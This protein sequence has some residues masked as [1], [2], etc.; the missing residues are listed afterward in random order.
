MQN[1]SPAV[2]L[3]LKAFA[4]QDFSEESNFF[5]CREE[6]SNISYI[7][8]KQSKDLPENDRIAFDNMAD[9][10]SHYPTNI[11]Y[12]SHRKGSAGLFNSKKFLNNQEI[13]DAKKAIKQTKGFVWAGIV[14]FTP[15]MAS[16]ICNNKNKA[17]ELVSAHIHKLFDNTF[18]NADNIEWYGAYHTNTDNPHI[19]LTLFEKEPMQLTSNGKKIYSSRFKIPIKNIDSFKFAIAQEASS[20]DY[21]FTKLRDPI[22]NALKTNVLN[23]KFHLKNILSLGKDIIKGNIFQYNRLPKEHKELVNKMVKYTLRN[24]PGTLDLYKEYENKLLDTQASFI[25]LAKENNVKPSKEAQ[26]FYSSRV[27]DLNGRLANTM[28]KILKNEHLR[29]IHKKQTLIEKYPK[30]GAY[31]PS[32]SKRFIKDSNRLD[33]GI[34][35]LKKMLQSFSEQVQKDIYMQTQ[36]DYTLEKKIRG[37]VAIYD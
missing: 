3:K 31:S 20:V 27:E 22:R 34:N 7:S 8:T 14:S 2:I 23:D 1:T 6:R 36:N 30:G 32:I 25:S 17:H 37:E 11:G 33:V 15:E 16:Q 5:R 12:A 19:H 18:L 9:L 35:E 26:S 10:S 21:V 13:E 28:L 24:F 4:P 29:E